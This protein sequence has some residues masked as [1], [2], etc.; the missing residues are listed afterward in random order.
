MPVS[1]DYLRGDRIG[2]QAEPLARDTLDLGVDRGVG[3]YRPGQLA[4]ATLL[5][6]ALQARVSAIEL[7]RPA[8]EL[9][10]EGRRLGVDSVRAADA[11]GAPVLFGPPDDGGER[12]VDPTQHEL[13]GVAHLQRERRVD[14]VG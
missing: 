7:E 1:C 4:D 14:D 13:A 2:L 3:A 5:E 10:A 11:H 12:T 6:C 9:P 8:G